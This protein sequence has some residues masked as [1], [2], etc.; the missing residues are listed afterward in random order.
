MAAFVCFISL[1]ALSIVD[2]S[3][4]VISTWSSS[5]MPIQFSFGYSIYNSSTRNIWV[6]QSIGFNTQQGYVD[7]S[8]T[9]GRFTVHSPYPMN[10]YSFPSVSYTSIN[11][12]IYFVVNSNSKSELR[13]F[14]FNVGNWTNLRYV[15]PNP[16]QCL[17]KTSDD[18][19]IFALGG[20]DSPDNIV[21]VYDVE[22]NGLKTIGPP[23]PVSNGG[24]SNFGCIVASDQ[25]L[26]IFGSQYSIQMPSA[27]LNVQNIEDIE[28]Q[29]WELLSFNFYNSQVQVYEIDNIIYI[30]RGYDNACGA[31]LQYI[32]LSDGDGSAASLIL[33]DAASPPVNRCYGSGVVADYKLYLFSGNVPNTSGNVWANTWYHSNYVGPP[34]ESPTNSPTESPTHSPT[35]SPT[36][37]PT[38]SPT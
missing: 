28:S 26:Y 15:L 6:M 9:N 22:A 14:S 5:T 12:T 29:N 1:L 24:A 3:V 4:N 23:L 21:L 25:Y 16:P 13:S 20:G 18:K 19:Y 17:T 34:T 2:S 7:Y 31:T 38:E 36:H 10:G 8:I 33:R 30:L 37:S 35:E 32:D 27:R 11:D